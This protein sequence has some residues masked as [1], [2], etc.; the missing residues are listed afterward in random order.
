MLVALY[1]SS[2]I[3]QGMV[4]ALITLNITDSLKVTFTLCMM[5]M[6]I[7]KLLAPTQ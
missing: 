7:T 6:M 5:I 1:I 3:F 4:M 2:L